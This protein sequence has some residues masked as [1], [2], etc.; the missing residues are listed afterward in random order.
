MGL[1]RALYTLGEETLRA[2]YTYVDSKH[3]T[4]NPAPQILNPVP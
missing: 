3:L 1:K 4:L 2:A